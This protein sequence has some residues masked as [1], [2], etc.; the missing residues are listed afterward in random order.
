MKK[1]GTKKRS[2]SPRLKWTLAG[3]AVL[4]ALL[5]SGLARET[6]RSRQIDREIE[7]LRAEAESLRARNF[8]IAA[9][10]S[11][12]DDEEFLEREARLKLG[13]KKAG[14]DVVVLKKDGATEGIRRVLG[15]ETDALEEWTPAKKWWMYFAD[16]RSYDDYAVRKGFR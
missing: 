11:S 7:A 15:A 16:R 9:L 8:E 4:V 3:L 14:E 10:T 13:L 1:R 2:A 6:L 12:L 5:G